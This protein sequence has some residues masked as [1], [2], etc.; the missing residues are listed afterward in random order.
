MYRFFFTSLLLLCFQAPGW[1]QTDPDYPEA[2]AQPT[3]IDYVEY[4][5]DEDPGFGNGTP[6]PASPGTDMTNL[7][8]DIPAAL[9][10]KGIHRLVVRSRDNRGAWSLSSIKD[11]YVDDPTPYPESVALTDIIAAEYFLDEDPGFGNGTSIPV[12]P[13]AD[14]GN[15]AESVATDGLPEG[16]HRLYIRTQNAAGTWS[17]T[18]VKEF[19]I[20]IEPAYPGASQ[21]A[22]DIIAAEYFIDGDPGFGNGNALPV[23]PGLQTE[24]LTV[25]IPVSGYSTGVHTLYIRTKNADD[26][27][28]LT[29]VRNFI[30]SEDFAYPSVPPSPSDIVRAEYFI[31]EDP[32]FGNANA[33]NIA[34]DVDMEDIL[35][36]I[37][38]SSYSSGIHRLYLRTM[39]AEAGWS[40][41]NHLDFVKSEDF[42]YPSAPTS[43][44]DI[45]FVEYFID[46]DPGFGNGRPIAIDPGLDLENIAFTITDTD[47][48]SP[49]AHMLYIRSLDDWSITNCRLFMVEEDL[50]LRLLS[51]TAAASGRHVLLN[52]STTDEE[53]TAFF[54]IE[55]SLDGSRFEKLAERP[56]QNRP[57][58]WHYRFVHENPFNAILYYRLKQVDSDQSYEYSPIRSVNKRHNERPI[59][60]PNPVG[61]ELTIMNVNTG[62]IDQTQIINTNGLI[63]ASFSKVSE[64]SQYVH[65]LKKGLYILR[66]IKKNGI[67]QTLSFIK[68]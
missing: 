21:P 28:S 23:T 63:V 27:W 11:F 16:V 57:G 68:D 39:N 60:V 9:L 18:S 10:P 13:A 36:A 66:L 56:S 7:T 41:T 53:N 1:A 67:P 59:I 64:L 14:I 8:A 51:F 43:P 35:Q 34:S 46:I 19:I 38:I 48:L 25:P 30:I 4:F 44:G 61:A 47:T 24:N 65:S 26:I 62:E 6:L 45:T 55:Y 3:E 58:V 15:L 42:P 2:S 17:V 31:D 37:D 33:I 12:S 49:G 5:F 22:A 40:M 20:I 50:P 32:G 54:E 29:T 52:W